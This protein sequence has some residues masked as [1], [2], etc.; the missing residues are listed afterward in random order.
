MERRFRP[1]PLHFVIATCLVTSTFAHARR[2]APREL[3]PAMTGDQRI[4]HT[5][6]RLAFGPRAA[7]VELMRRIGVD[8][9]I[10]QQLHPETIPENPVLETKLQPLETLYLSSAELM[11]QYPSGPIVRAMAEGRLPL[12]TDPQKRALAREL[13]ARF[14][15]KQGAAGDLDAGGAGAPVAAEE[16]EAHQIEA[17]QIEA[18]GAEEQIEALA[19]L[20]RARL[21]ELRIS[22]STQMQRRIQMLNSPMQVMNQD[23]VAAK[24]IRAVYSN[25]Q[26]E[27]V[28]T[29]FWYNHFNVFLD[30]GQDRYF[31]PAYERDV[32]RPHVLGSFHDLL[33][34]TAESPA[35][36]FYLDNW[37]SAGPDA[38]PNPNRRQRGLNE[39]YARELMELH[40]LGVDGGYTQKDVTE[41]AR[42]LTGWTIRGPQ[43]GGG[44]EFNARMHDAGEKRVLGV[45]IP[46]D[47]GMEDGLKVIDILAT[48]PSTAHFI[49]KQLAIRFVA[50]DPPEALVARM[51]KKFLETRGDLREVMRAMIDSPEFRDPKYFRSKIKSPFEL[52]ASAAR[53]V[54]GDM[55]YSFARQPL[56]NQLGEPLYRKQEPN[57]YSNVGADWLNGGSLIARMNF[58]T[59]LAGNK[60]VGIKADVSQFAGDPTSLERALLLTNVSTETDQTTRSA[61]GS[62]MAAVALASPDFQRR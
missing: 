51:A 54:N 19:G 20:P 60:V 40:T 30:K 43:R 9:W 11:E 50:D 39:N 28:L 27:E 55:D 59:A 41:V 25:R 56:L 26:L 53:A 31:V 62:S 3:T 47:G 37:Q 14:E 24:L 44:F 32:I 1:K 38:R 49:S 10:E 4:A 61:T 21:R 17:H 45:T 5:L 57:G 7:D 23:L 6:N 36:L 12:P 46:A 2:K 18:M 58:A 34:A 13:V 29:D 8:R 42:C 35:M 33:L 52:V 48:H 15:R 16:R 22:G